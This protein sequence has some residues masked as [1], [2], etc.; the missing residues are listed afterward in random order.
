MKNQISKI[1]VTAET[2]I[3]CISQPVDTCQELINLK[4]S[5]KQI[6]SIVIP[7]ATCMF[8]TIFVIFL[9]KSACGIN[10]NREDLLDNNGYKRNFSNNNN[11][12]DSVLETLYSCL[13]SVSFL[14][15]YTC[16]MLLIIKLNWMK[17]ITF[18]LYFTLAFLFLFVSVL[19]WVTMLTAIDL[20]VDCI[21]FFLLIVNN[22]VLAFFCIMWAGPR[23]LAQ[24][25][26]I[27]LS[28]LIAWFLNNQTTIWFGWLILVIL[29]IWDLFAVLPK[30]GPLNLIIK[31]L[32]KRGQNIPNALIYSTYL[33]WSHLNVSI[34]KLNEPF[35]TLAENLNQNNNNFAE[36]D[37]IEN[38]MNITDNNLNMNELENDPK[39]GIGDFV[40]Y[41]LLIAKASTQLN[42]I[43]LVSCF[44]GII[45]GLLI[46]M[47]VVAYL[48]RPMPALPLSI[49]IAM[50]LFFTTEI[51]VAPFC[52]RLSLSQTFI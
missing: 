19:F 44:L 25:Y 43:T 32:D 48:K 20:I 37:L 51:I 10:Y 45:I 16:L 42:V 7:V 12:S 31:I 14:I 11:I 50:I 3:Q 21:T 34:Q 15:F 8:I 4:Y 40:F 41:S 52:D 22:A 5:P 13:I 38:Q 29:S 35:E 36:N 26:H 30:Y 1:N 2:S 27:H 46:T 24:A 28:I 17:L 9:T 49:F 47:L 6:L 39:L 18:I 33:E 23:R